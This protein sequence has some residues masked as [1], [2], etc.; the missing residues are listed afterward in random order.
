MES[1]AKLIHYS[2]LTYLPTNL[3]A[4]FFGMPDN[5]VYLI[6]GRYY[7]LNSNKS[8][9]EFIFA[10][11]SEFSY[12]YQNSKLVPGSISNSKYPVYNGMVDKPEPKFE[13]LKVL[14]DIHSYDEVIEKMNSKAKRMVNKRNK[15]K[16][17]EAVQMAIA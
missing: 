6:Y 7:K 15:L 17:G 12:D 4:L 3:P 14:N 5:K 8:E 16:I 13:I 10:V 11:H 1:V 9:L 2:H